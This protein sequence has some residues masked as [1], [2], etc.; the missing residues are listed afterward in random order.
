M[1]WLFSKNLFVYFFVGKPHILY[2]EFEVM[3]LKLVLH[4][5]LKAGKVILEK[6]SESLHQSE[7]K[8]NG[9]QQ[10]QFIHFKVNFLIWFGK[11][12]KGENS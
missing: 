2:S 4:H 1:F 8:A 7:N 9:G 6:H 10:K 12:F 5:D 11:K 3:K